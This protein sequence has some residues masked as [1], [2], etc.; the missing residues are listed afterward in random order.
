[1]TAPDFFYRGYNEKQGFRNRRL[2][3]IA[4]QIKRYA[5]ARNTQ[6]AH[7]RTELPEN[8]TLRQMLRRL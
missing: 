6:C 4:F 1:M 7:P 3:K 8:W 5:F 2:Q